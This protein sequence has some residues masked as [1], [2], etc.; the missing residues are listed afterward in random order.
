MLSI[1]E[2]KPAIISEFC[3]QLTGVGRILEDK[4]NNVWGCSPIYGPDGKV[5]LFY[6]RWK[7]EATHLG[8]LS[9]CEIAHAI[10]D[11]PEGPYETVDIALTGRGGDW[12][13]SMTCHNPTIH[14]IGDKYALFY[15]GTT[16][17]SVY[18]KR[19]GMA[20]S[21]SLYGPWKRCDTPIIETTQIVM[22]G[23]QYVHLTPL[24]CNTLMGSYGSI[25][26]VGQ[27]AIGKK[28]SRR[29]IGNAQID[30]MD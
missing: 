7:N 21:D 15:I 9:C 6:S 26:R 29:E 22:H 28:T 24:Y 2:N 23:I 1:T 10:A 30:N 5:H 19:I 12:W 14:K 25:I 17:G 18:S 11:K 3:Y 16:E 13:D 20:T 4:D 8:W 27:L